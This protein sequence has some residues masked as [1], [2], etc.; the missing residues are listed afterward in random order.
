MPL[1]PFVPKP[2]IDACHTP[3]L[4]F[5]EFFMHVFNIAILKHCLNMFQ[6]ARAGKS[7]ARALIACARKSARASSAR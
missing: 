7:H 2:A 6:S 1:V 3:V 4:G 5:M